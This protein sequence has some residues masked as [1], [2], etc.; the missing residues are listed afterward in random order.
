MARP[1]MTVNESNGLRIEAHLGVDGAAS[2]IESNGSTTSRSLERELATA[3]AREKRL[4]AER[5]RLVR[6]LEEL[7]TENAQIVL[8]SEARDR[9]EQLLEAAD[10]ER[11]QLRR[12]RRVHE[13][14]LTSLSWR[15]TAPLRWGVALLRSLRRPRR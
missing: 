8:L 2:E 1:P 13:D 4:L 12:L 7:E 15:L 3:L 10:D 9:A 11:Q 14:T 5:N 6:T